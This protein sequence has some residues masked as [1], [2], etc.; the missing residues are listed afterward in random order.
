MTDVPAKREKMSMQNR[1]LV[2]SEHAHTAAREEQRKAF[3]W[4]GARGAGSW[5]LAWMEGGAWSVVGGR[6]AD[7]L[8]HTRHNPQREL[9]CVWKIG[10]SLTVSV[11]SVTS[12]C[13]RTT[14][15]PPA[16][17][18]AAAAAL[19]RPSGQPAMARGRVR[20]W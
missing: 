10:R 17:R 3:C 18:R 20:R 13:V 9:D 4:S 14:G 5:L 1:G 19:R 12:V 15:P 7:V 2:H 6:L 16:V 8:A 11:E